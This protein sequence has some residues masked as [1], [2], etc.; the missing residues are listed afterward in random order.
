M[1]TDVRNSCNRRGCEVNPYL[2]HDRQLDI[3]HSEDNG[4]GYDISQILLA[5]SFFLDQM[6]EKEEQMEEDFAQTIGIM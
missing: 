4:A 1:I 6:E 3:I 5:T 2:P